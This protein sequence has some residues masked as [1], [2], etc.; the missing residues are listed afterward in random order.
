M[1]V[2]YINAMT[3]QRETE[4][5]KREQHKQELYVDGTCIPNLTQKISKNN[6]TGVKGVSWDK[7]RLK[8]KAQIYFKGKCYP[9]GRFDTIDEAI[10]ARQLAEKQLFEPL[11]NK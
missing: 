5:E 3:E 4:L 1:N 10:K 11:I 2:D 8:W 6:K 7:A 9:L